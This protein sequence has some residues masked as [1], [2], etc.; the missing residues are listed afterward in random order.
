MLALTVIGWLTTILL[1]GF[2]FLGV[3]WIW[4]VVDAFLL[5]KMISQ[6]NEEIEAEIINEIMNLRQARENDLAVGVED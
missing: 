3:V 5:S 1:I 4:W 6:K 2:V